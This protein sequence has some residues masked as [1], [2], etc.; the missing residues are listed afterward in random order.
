M[1]IS[2]IQKERTII[3]PEK[4]LA[5]L[6]NIE[7]GEDYFFNEYPE[8]YPDFEGRCWAFY[9]ES[10]LSEEVEMIGVGKAPA[11]QQLALYLKCYQQS[12]KKGEIHSPE[13]QI[14]IGRVAN[15]FVIA[16]DDGDFLYLDPED[17]FSV[18][19]FYHD[20]CDVK[21]VSNSMAEWLKRAKAA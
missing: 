4:Y 19:V 5:F 9:D 8:E 3:L 2:K 6:A 16:E 14:A 12:T 21:K 13:G 10:L 18:W 7:A 20:G 11:H 15:A 17:N 1:K